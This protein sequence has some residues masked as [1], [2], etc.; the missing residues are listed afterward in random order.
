MA[1][2]LLI[3]RPL[4]VP[5]TS[6]TSIPIF[7]SSPSCVSFIGLSHSSSKISPDDVGSRCVGSPWLSFSVIVRYHHVAR[8]ASYIRWGQTV[9]G[10]TAC[11]MDV[12]G[13]RLLL[14]IVELGQ[15]IPQAYRPRMARP[16]CADLHRSYPCGSLRVSPPRRGRILRGAPGSVA[17][18]VQ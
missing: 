15:P 4:T 10:Q 9:D 11:P 6:W 1:R 16:A 14:A 2:R 12:N 7:F 17:R 5:L 13:F 18:R 3:R 8:F